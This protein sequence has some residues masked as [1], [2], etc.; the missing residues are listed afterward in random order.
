MIED[1][2]S[3]KDSNCEEMAELNGLFIR[4]AARIE[5]LKAGLRQVSSYTETLERFIEDKEE[6]IKIMVEE[7]KVVVRG[8][9][10]LRLDARIKASVESGRDINSRDP[11]YIA[12]N[13]TKSEVYSEIIKLLDDFIDK[14][15]GGER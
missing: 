1:F 2:I 12:R 3:E 7:L 4:Q 13:R 15:N 9:Y 11:V 6:R 10:K 5:T 8:L 14:H